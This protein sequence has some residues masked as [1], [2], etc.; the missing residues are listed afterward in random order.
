MHRTRLPALRAPA[1]LA[2]CVLTA[3]VV[4]AGC[5]SGGAAPQVAS[6]G[7]AGGGAGTA[8]GAGAGDDVSAYLAGQKSYVDCMRTAGYD[9]PDPDENGV[10]AVGSS[11]TVGKT[12]DPAQ[13]AADERCSASMKPMPESISKKLF[14]PPTD[15][16][17][18]QAKAYAQCM[19]DNG[20]PEFLDPDLDAV[21]GVE[22]P[23]K[24]EQ[25][26]Q[27]EMLAN[28]SYQSAT[29]TCGEQVYDIQPGTA[30]G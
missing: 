17:V 4:L 25:D 24:A 2:G 29:S 13:A 27:D 10:I 18:A 5:S 21:P 6:A 28:P 19:R 8:T 7:G 11:G 1:L 20:V 23:S 14:V 22:Q 12:V 15:E 26:A 16:Q 30:G 9:L 3:T